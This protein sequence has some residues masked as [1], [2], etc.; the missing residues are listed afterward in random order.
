MNGPN[1]TTE[2]IVSSFTDELE[3]I[4]SDLLRMGGIAESMILDA[5]EAVSKDDKA[6]AQRVVAQDPEVDAL[7]ADVEKQIMVVIAKR[8][9]TA[10]DLRTVMSAL[11]VAGELER[12]GDLSRNIAKRSMEL[13]DNLGNAMRNGI[14]RM[15]RAVSR[16]LND[17]LDAYSANDEIAART[18]WEGDDDID[19][20]YNSLF[21]EMMTYMIED[22]RTISAGAHILFMAKNLERV[23]DHCTNIAEFVHFQATGSYLIPSER[24][25]SPN[26]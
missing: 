6:L 14:M 17:V 22:P 12:V 24:P 4:A 16:Q 21:R 19:Q 25:K 1:T 7:E 23:G 15:G 10:Q 26:V 11:K 13:D 8:Q 2:N 20:F 5:C 18:V 3:Q 9:P